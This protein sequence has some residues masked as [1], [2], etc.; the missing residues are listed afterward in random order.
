[1]DL[2]NL[3]P[4]SGA[5]RDRKRLGRGPGSGL[6]KTSGRG[7]KGKG[8]RSGGNTPPGYEGGQMPLQRRLPKRGFNNPFRVEYSV[9]NLG[10]L[11]KVFAANDVV[12][13]Q[14][15]QAKHLVRPRASMVK[16]LAKGQVSK[17]L[18]VKAHKF[19]AAARA[20]LEAAGGSVE[21]LASA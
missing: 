1:M 11:E 4:T 19:S 6:G 16:I 8:A 3:K 15:L 2:S 12:D 5:V 9:V 20:Q 7:H 18:T 17:P 13:L 10:Q 14:A 21:E